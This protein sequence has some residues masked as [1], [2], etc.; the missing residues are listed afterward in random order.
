MNKTLIYL[1]SALAPA[2]LA[3]AAHA[4]QPGA[5]PGLQAMPTPPPIL[6]Q[7]ATMHIIAPPPP[8]PLPLPPQ[9]SGSALAVHIPLGVPQPMPAPVLPVLTGSA[10]P[11]AASTPSPKPELKLPELPRLTGSAAGSASPSPNP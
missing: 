8:T 4:Q 7:S 9:L 11:T 6:L 10:P 3:A 5:T 1:K 2:L